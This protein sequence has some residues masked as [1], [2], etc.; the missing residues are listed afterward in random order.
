MYLEK[1]EARKD[2]VGEGQQ[3]FNRPAEQQ[4]GSQSAS[5]LMS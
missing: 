2:Y 4:F 5:E 3:Q 1:T